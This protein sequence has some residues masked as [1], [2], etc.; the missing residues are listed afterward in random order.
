MKFKLFILIIL[1]FF[2]TFSY[3][4]ENESNI[5]ILVDGNVVKYT[6]GKIIYKES[7]GIERSVDVKIIPGRVQINDSDY[8]ELLLK[9]ID[10][11][12]LKFDYSENCNEKI[13][14]YSYEIEDFKL[15]W[16]KSDYIILNVYN[17]NK[18][19]YTK[20]YNPLLGKKYTYEYEYPGGAMKRAKRKISKCK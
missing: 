11:I 15:N 9:N 10:K 17:T 2:E 3:A 5:I 12:Y 8:Q 1:S 4:Q 14:Y 19:E 7:S 16:L 6:N 18:S 20:I 13:E